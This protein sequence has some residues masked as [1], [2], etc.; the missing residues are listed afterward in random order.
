MRMPHRRWWL[1][2]LPLALAAT[3]CTGSSSATSTATRTVVEVR[4]A[5]APPGA[6]GLQSAFTQAIGRMAPSV[7]Q[8]RSPSGLGSG[9]VFDRQGDIVTNAHVVGTF[10]RFGVI[11][12]N[13]TH[14]KGTLVGTF[15]PNDVAVV[16]A[17]ASG[18]RPAT[19]ADSS[20]LQPGDLVLAMGSPLGLRGSVTDGIVSA[21]GRTVGEPTGATLPGVIQTSAPINPGNSGGALVDI[22]GRVVGIPTLT[23]VDQQI[24]GQAPGIGFAIPSNT[25]RDL[26]R[27]MIAHGHVVNSHRAF[28]GVRLAPSAAG[29]GAVVVRVEPGSAAAKAGIKPNDRIVS[30]DGHDT[31]SP[32]AVAGVLAG[33]RPGQTIP[34]EVSGPS[35]RRTLQ[36]TLGSIPGTTG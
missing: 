15:P 28:L 9:I 7:V 23:A 1:A 36:V 18:L 4:Q 22:E 30:V 16:K 32:D 13:G 27:Q 20:R 24:G 2:A 26:A 6:A 14:V 12:A 31:P 35:G 34:V 3:A 21:T 10:H 19:F 17:A 33:L 8:I 5:A 29:E 11:L 25:V